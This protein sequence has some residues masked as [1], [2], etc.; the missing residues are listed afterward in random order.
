MTTET[1]APPA[2][3]AL[4]APRT[5][6][7]GALAIVSRGR[8]LTGPQLAAFD[9]ALGEAAADA[10][11]REEVLAAGRRGYRAA[12]VPVD[13]DLP[14][15]EAI[16]LLAVLALFALRAGDEPEEAMW[17]PERLAAARRWPAD[18][19][20]RLLGRLGPLAQDARVDDLRG[21]LAALLRPADAEREAASWLAATLDPP[22]PAKRGFAHVAASRFQHPS[23]RQ[24]MEITA[25]IAG[26]D[27]LTRIIFEQG[28]EKAFRLIN[29]SSAIR[30]GPDQFP[31]LWRIWQGC[32]ARAGVDP[33]IEL[34]V[35]PGGINAHTSG[36]E[37]PYVMLDSG[38][39]GC[40]TRDELEFIIGHELGH[41]RCEHMLHLFLIQ[42]LPFVAGR[43][44]VVGPLL[45]LGIGAALGDWY[46]KA[47]LS[48]D[49]AGLLTCQDP[50]AA[51]R[52]MMKW[53]GAPGA[54]YQRLDQAAF[55]R[56]A[57]EFRDLDRDL[58]SMVYKL[59]LTMNRTHPWT[60]ER[61]A[62]IVAWHRDGHA[63]TILATEVAAGPA[64]L[65]GGDVPAEAPPEPPSP[66]RLLDR[67]GRI[68]TAAD[69][70]GL[71]LDATAL[72]EAL[73]ARTAAAR[74][75]IVLVGEKQRGKTTVAGKL[76]AVLGGEVALADTPG[77]NDADAAFEDE[78]MPAV[79]RADAVLAVVSAAQLLSAEERSLLRDRVLP[80]APGR[81]AL[82]VTHLD[83]LETDADRADLV[84]RLERFVARSGRGDLAVFHM[85][86]DL[87]AAAP[88]GLV[89]WVRAAALAAR[90]ED[91]GAW[92]AKAAALLDVLDGA[93]ASAPADA[94]S[95]TPPGDDDRAAVRAA[96]Q[97][98][99]GL[100]LQAAEAHAAGRLAALRQE[101]PAR[102]ARLTPA[103][104]AREGV[105]GL[106][107]D[108]QRVA[109]EAAGIYL[110]AFER[111]L[112]A[113][114][115]LP[116]HAA[117]ALR[118]DGDGLAAGVDGMAGVRVDAR[119]PR[120]YVTIGLTVVGTGFALF[121]GGVAGLLV[122]GVT[123]AA[124]HVVRVQT[125]EAFRQRLR[126]DATAAIDAW[127][128]GAERGIAERLREGAE[129][130]RAAI[131]AQAEAALD[132]PPPLEAGGT[133][134]EALREAIAACRAQLGSRA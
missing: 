108:V 119:A 86:A 58:L 4:A 77:L 36:V 43:V 50:E 68:A 65:G 89:A 1:Q 92:D 64:L 23:D 47:E 62:E 87:A 66:E 74:P 14:Q 20:P 33:T 31:E 120:N 19:V 75:E 79:L 80:M 41:I 102:V 98:E 110:A 13:V 30:V 116:D 63:E 40:L 132:R 10:A 60:V 32:V 18:A 52:V 118:P 26:F 95:W 17:V 112:V 12:E 67:L 59:L 125:D 25:G 37:R 57:E 126:E 85:P 69:A 134:V 6:F 93:A 128:G 97:R 53:S 99:H 56:Q 105:A 101:V 133:S 28:F 130:V 70:L 29:L 103:A 100:A 96:I 115:G 91:Q 44:P 39:V 84:G 24:A 46:R 90:A 121:G 61:A 55:L 54:Y 117:G 71:G 27:D 72:V 106:T 8:A 73:G 129:P 11:L 131:A 7:L 114:A 82:V 22:R 83:A 88:E 49:R 9:L 5:A 111:G 113:R 109:R 123:I 38:A 45:E 51:V 78:V 122:G 81:T 3:P 94:G 48:C 104:L 21:H 16:A 34:Y 127:L 2:S 15:D 42:V 76:A 35:K 107:G 124:A